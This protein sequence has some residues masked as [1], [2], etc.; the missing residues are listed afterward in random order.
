[1]VLWTGL[2]LPWSNDPGATRR[3]AQRDIERVKRASYLRPDQ[4]RLGPVLRRSCFALRE[5]LRIVVFATPWFLGACA[6]TSGP[7]ERPST[8]GEVVDTEVGQFVRP[9]GPGV[10]VAVMRN[11]SV[12]F[13][14][15]YGMADL[16]AP[17]PVGRDSR[18]YL[19]SVSK[20][21]TSM[22]V[23]LLYEDGLIAFDDEI[24]EVLPEAPESWSP[25]T[26]HHLLTH[27]SGIGEYLEL[28]ATSN[29]TNDD[30]LAHAVEQDLE[31]TPGE[32][33]EYSN[34]GYVLL[35]VLVERISGLP[36]E[37]Y[38]HER[39]FAPLGMSQ[40]VVAD[41]SRPAVPMR[42]VGYWPNGGLHD[43][44]LRTMGDGGIFSSLND[45]EIWMSGLGSSGLV[46]QETL[47][48][49]FTSHEGHGYGYGWVVGELEGMKHLYH[50]GALVGYAA[51]VSVIPSEQLAL[52]VLSNGTFR[53]E[54]PDLA[55]R[56]LYFYLAN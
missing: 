54:V 36:F 15:G 29:W 26:I 8:I 41:P 43:Y 18:F 24:I 34:T 40:S 51:R 30:V 25:I 32:R 49:A 17:L 38:V 9:D 7:H 13:E 28:P 48:L 10:A 55:A 6:S 39:I 56:I 1:M 22:A 47:G 50:A 23:M 5:V 42:A 35:A 27:Q 2:L 12:V 14:K 53:D 4:E 31:F 37:T 3:R 11:G 19:A 33:Y 52:V 21:I 46:S 45:M 44:P 16:E 20:Q